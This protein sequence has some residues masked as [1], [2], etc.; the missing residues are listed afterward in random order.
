M[1]DSGG[2]KTGA[3]RLEWLDSTRGLSIFW[4]ACF[5][6]FIAYDTGRYPWPVSLSSLAAFVEKCSGL[7]G[8]GHL[9]CAAEGV[10]AGLFERGPH[11]VGVFLALSGF[12]LAY[13]LARSQNGI[14]EGGVA[15]V[16][17]G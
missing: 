12:G 14:P 8:R 6:F 9:G 3:G 1:S 17:L 4:I 10:V 13:S 2:A 5:H 16:V 15:P 11:E 7:S